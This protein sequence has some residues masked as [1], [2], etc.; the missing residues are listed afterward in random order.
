MVYTRIH[1]CACSCVYACVCACARGGQRPH[2][3]PLSFSLFCFKT[4]FLHGPRALRWSAGKPALQKSSSLHIPSPPQDQGCRCVL[5]HLASF[6]FLILFYVHGCFKSMHMWCAVCVLGIHEGPKMVLDSWDLQWEVVMCAGNA[7]PLKEQQVR[8]TTDP[9][10]PVF[11]CLLGFWFFSFSR[12]SWGGKV[13]RPTQQTFPTLYLYSVLPS[14]WVPISSS[15][16]REQ[17]YLQGSGYKDSENVSMTKCW[18][19]S[20][21]FKHTWKYYRLKPNSISQNPLTQKAFWELKI[22]GSSS[23]NIIKTNSRHSRS[24]LEEG[25]QTAQTEVW[26]ETRISTSP[27]ITLCVLFL[28]PSSVPSVAP[29]GS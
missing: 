17:R 1:I 11:V 26:S 19:L 23:F 16:K 5:P 25:V 10:V 18:L 28:L 4:G 8:W 27:A 9:S 2:S 14:P 29:G 20:L 24:P 21:D 7:G 6:I 3:F 12:R 15:R 22:S 13:L